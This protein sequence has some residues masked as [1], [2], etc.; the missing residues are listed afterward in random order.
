MTG[1]EAFT[2]GE[3]WTIMTKSPTIRVIPLSLTAAFKA[4]HVGDTM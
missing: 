4:L 2:K 3:A 1:E